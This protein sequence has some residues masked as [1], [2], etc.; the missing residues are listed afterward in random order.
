MDKPIFYGN[1]KQINPK[2]D[3]G[4]YYGNVILICFLNIDEPYVYGNEKYIK[5][6]DGYRNLPWI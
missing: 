4:I 5:N 1:E 6:K 2:M 3:R